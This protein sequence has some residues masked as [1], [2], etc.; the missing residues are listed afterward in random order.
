MEELVIIPTKNFY[1]E[2]YFSIRF[3]FSKR[4]RPNKTQLVSHSEKS[5]FSL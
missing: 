4:T 3:N 2:S 5:F 1:N